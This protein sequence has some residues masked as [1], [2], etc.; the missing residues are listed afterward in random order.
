MF[1]SICSVLLLLLLTFTGITVNAKGKQVIMTIGGDKIYSDEFLRMYQKNNL[2]LPDSLQKTPQQYLQLFIDFK[3]KV[4]AAEA[5]GMDTLSSFK[6]ELARYREESAAPYLTDSTIDEQLVRTMY[7]RMTTEVKA[8][9]ILIRIPR[10]ASPADTLKAWNQI[11]DLRQRAVNGDD[12]AELALN[13]SQDPSAR[14]NKGELGYFSGFM[15]VYPFEKAAYET[16]VGQIS[17]IVRTRF[18]YHLI[19]VEDK[20]PSP[21]EMHAAHIMFFVRPGSS[22][23]AEA[24][25]HA[26]AD[27]VYQML[28]KGADFAQLAKKYSDDKKSGANGGVLPWFRSGRMIPEIAKTAFAL[29]KDGDYSKPVRSPYGWHIVKRLA[30]KPVPTF[31]EL[32]PKIIENLKKSPERNQE[33]KA[34]FIRKLKSEYTFYEN[35]TT[36]KWLSSLKGNSKD[37]LLAKAKEIENTTLFTIDKKPFVKTEFIDFIQQKEHS[38]K[39]LTKEQIDSYYDHF[40]DQSFLKYEDSQLE[41]K[42]PDFR[43]LVKE[44]HD[45]LLLFNITDQKVWQKAAKDTTGLK[46][47]YANH[48]ENYRTERYFDGTV[49]LCPSHKIATEVDKMVEAGK[50]STF[51]IQK[52]KNLEGFSRR[53][54]KFRKGDNPAVDFY[55]FND[56]DTITEAQAGLAVLQGKTHPEG[57]E[58]LKDVRGTCLADYQDY[59]EKQWVKQLRQKY[60]VKV[61][62]QAMKKILKHT[63]EK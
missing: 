1:K 58:S 56:K 63:A 44:Y 28:Q 53:T 55:I 51:I 52:L 36:P 45:G 40:K 50:D 17:P 57:Y 27:S 42:Y 8:S 48:R 9:H 30:V 34:A 14:N 16:P 59:L 49:Y 26:K 31:D 22:P 21:G 41:K 7:H 11:N 54:G 25:I 13:Y 2:S 47:F 61:K 39:P 62:H 10:N 32:R 19:K 20:R 35:P 15:M 38:H 12:F 24:Q 18:G 46:E 29:K 33:A 43:L 37:S 5:L 60:P 6:S 3:L 23:E 4:R